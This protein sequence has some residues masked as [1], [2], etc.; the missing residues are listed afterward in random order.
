MNKP[1]ISIGMPIYNAGM[2]LRL[3]LKSILLQTFK[4][5]ELI[6]LDDGSTDDAIKRNIGLLKDPR[7]SLIQDGKNFGLANR[8]NQAISLA[9]GDYFARMDQDDISYP[10]RLTSQILALEKQPDWDL[11]GTRFLTINENEIPIG[12]SPLITEHHEIVS[13]PWRGLYLAHPTWMGKKSWFAKNLYAQPGPYF[14]EDQELLLR[15]HQ[16]S[17]FANLP[18]ILFAYRL[19]EGINWRKSSK[20]RATLLRIRSEFFVR[21][22]NYNALMKSY[23]QYGIGYLYDSLSQISIFQ[24]YLWQLNVRIGEVPE[25]EHQ[26]LRE[27]FDLMTHMEE[28][29]RYLENYG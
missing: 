18:D 13:A 3:A 9:R 21:N 27:I 16:N 17:V 19:R 1:L 14:C 12:M 10:K 7:I 8:L 28:S 23:T 22:K 29:V 26:R 20:I 4:D 25:I 15:T 5:W 11:L 6:V 24:N 2:F